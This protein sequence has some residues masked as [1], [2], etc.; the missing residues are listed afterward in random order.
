[1]KRPLAN[2][3]KIKYGSTWASHIQEQ[4]AKKAFLE[5]TMLVLGSTTI[6]RLRDIINE[7]ILE[8]YEDKPHD[9]DNPSWAYK[10]AHSNGK[11]QALVRL[12]ELLEIKES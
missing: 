11:R 1:M 6:D 3:F 8:T 2:P 12:L 7:G 4:E 5:S 9:Y 10:Q